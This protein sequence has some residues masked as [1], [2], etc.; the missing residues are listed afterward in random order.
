MRKINILLLAGVVMSLGSCSKDETITGQ[1]EGKSGAPQLAA[2]VEQLPVT[3]SGVIENNGNYADGEKFY[4]SN[5]DATTVLFRNPSMTEATQYKKAEYVASVAGGVQSNNC[6]FQATQPE[7]LDNGTYTAYGLYP[8]SAWEVRADYYSFLETNIPTYQTQTQANSTHLGA[9]MLMKAQSDVTVDGSTPI[10]LTY[11]HLASV[12]RFVVWNNSGNNNLRL[13]NIIVKLSSGKAVFAT[14]AKLTDVDAT[15]LSVSDYMNV[16]V[17]TLRLTG[18]ARNFSTQDGKKRCEGY[19]VVLPTATDAFEDSDD[20]MFELSFSEGNNNYLVTKTYPIGTSLQ[21]LSNGIEQGKSY[22]F[23][24]KVESGDLNA[25]TGTSYAV[26]DY[27]PDNT[28]PV[29][30]VFWVKPGSL[31]TQGKVVGLGETYVT[32]WGVDNDEQAAGVAGIRSVTDGAT[33]TKSMIAK[34]KSSGTFSADYPAFHYIYNT[35][36]SGNENG[37]W[38]LPARDELKMLY[39][40]YSGKVYEEITDWITSKMPGYDSE[41]CKMARAAFN[42]SLTA[43]G[44]MAFGSSGNSANWYYLSSSEVVSTRSYSFNLEDGQYS[45]DEK[46]M[47]GN[48][49]WIRDF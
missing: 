4:W 47:D 6:T 36:N 42:S 45:M 10:K 35:M 14:K 20:L 37:V 2:T 29:G 7:S 24:L 19:M 34:Y 1:P 13:E 26:G 44:G 40:G 46:N 27:W 38:Y 15:S 48:I 8:T 5:G 23:Q 11:N 3:R 21:F 30:I 16:P 25:I 12:V 41:N 43:K 39:A 31:G 28:S 33:A 22:Y 9:Y 49:R 32:K 17:L 18:D